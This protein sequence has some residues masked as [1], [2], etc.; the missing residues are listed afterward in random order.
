MKTTIKDVAKYCNYSVTTVSYALNGSKEIPDSTKQ[1]ILKAAK[2]LN[3]VP[4][5][6]ASGLK[7]QKTF[8]IAVF[9]SDFDGPI[10]HIVLSGM[11]E[12]FRKYDNRYHM[13][14]MTSKDNLSIVKSR[15]VDLAIIMNPLLD[16]ELLKDLASIVPIIVLDKFIEGD[17]IYVADIH[18]EEGM[19]LLASNLIK[20]GCT[21]IGYLLGSSASYHNA[22]RFNG[23]KKALKD[24]GL[25]YDENNV[26]NADAFTEDAGYKTIFDALKD[27]GDLKYDALMCGNDELAIGAIRALRDR[28]Y[29]VPK[30]TM[31]TGFDNIDKGSLINPSLTTLDVDWFMF[32]EYVAK[33]AI[34]I[35]N[36]KTN[37]PLLYVNSSK[38][39]ERGST[40]E[41]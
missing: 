28:G 25:E 15:L 2:E 33:Y 39:I 13:M 4:S 24:N 32:G 19:Y 26:F 11:A 38:I 10:H 27:G 29:A 23:Y 20:K 16:D 34:D 12:G 18:N 35:M 1:K 40:M 41:K 14:V 22:M 6:L 17:N 37:D 9:I 30:D 5:A 7:R 8:N 3:Y 21:K 31:V 36:K